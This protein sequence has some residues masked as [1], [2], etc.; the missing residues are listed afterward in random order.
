MNIHNRKGTYSMKKTAMSCL[1][2]KC[3]SMTS[4][5]LSRIVFFSSYKNYHVLVNDID[6]KWYSK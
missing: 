4:K 3:S 2:K 1:F 5:G 6:Y